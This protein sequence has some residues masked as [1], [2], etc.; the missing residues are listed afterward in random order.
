M[1][2]QVQRHHHSTSFGCFH[3]ILE[4]DPQPMTGALEGVG[5]LLRKLRGEDIDWQAF[6]ECRSPTA[7]C[8]KCEM[9]RDISHF[10]DAE[11]ELA[12]AIRPAT[13]IVCTESVIGEKRKRDLKTAKP[14][15]PCARCKH[16]K[17]MDAFPRA[18]L[19][20][21]DASTK[22]ICLK[23]LHVQEQFVCD[24]CKTTKDRDN[25]QPQVLTLPIHR[26]CLVC[27][28]RKGE[29]RRGWTTCRRCAGLIPTAGLAEGS[30]ERCPNF[31]SRSTW[32][33]N[34][35]TCKRCQK[36]FTSSVKAQSEARERHCPQCR[37]K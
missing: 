18:Q 11:W 3:A 5:I 7:I 1:S 28:P 9:Q 22:Q 34:V 19:E 24:I 33:S 17:I 36:K 25:F 37:N 30:L 14:I 20:Q 35:H 13:C 2:K 15:Y 26:P 4:N 21:A 12:R 23:C 16:N 27:Q 29:K 8:S 32:Q 31:R 10:T 6:R